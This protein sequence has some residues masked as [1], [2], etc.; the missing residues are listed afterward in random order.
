MRFQQS[1]CSAM[2][3]LLAAAAF[4]CGSS[5][6]STEELF[7]EVFGQTPQSGISEIQGADSRGVDS[8]IWLRFISENQ[9]S[10]Q[11]FLVESGFEVKPCDQLPAWFQMPERWVG[12]AFSPSWKVPSESQLRCFYH[13][14]IMGTYRWS[15]YAA[16][17]QHSDQVYVAAS[18]LPLEP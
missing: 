16:L 18:T 2:I 11:R 17:D 8:V 3:L 6:P 9:S 5:A 12:D 10:G 13:E 4:G 15:K 7:F 14:D 1:L